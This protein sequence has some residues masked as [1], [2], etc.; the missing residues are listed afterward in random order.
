MSQHKDFAELERPLRD[1]RQKVEN[2]EAAARQ[3]NVSEPRLGTMRDHLEALERRI[4]SQ[5]DAWDKTLIAR[6]AQRPYSLDYI[7]SIFEEFVELHGDRQGADDGAIITGVGRFEGRRTAIIAQQKGRDIK[8]RKAR[9]FGM[10][11]PEGYRKAM[12]IMDLADRFGLPVVSFVDT[13]AADPGVE[14]EQRGISWAIA[15]SMR[16]MFALRV[17]T[18]AAV[19][20]EGGSGGAI[21]IACSNKVLMLEYAVYSVIPPEGCAA[22]LWRD[23]NKKNEAATALKLT[24]ADALRLG[25]VDAIV[26]EPPGAAHTYPLQVTQ[27]LREALSSALASLDGLS[28]DDLV[29][30]RRERFSGL[31]SF[32]N[33]DITATKIV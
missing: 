10:A 9:N 33:T 19:I 15:E 12:R 20:G 6:H 14:S 26:A 16:R 30:Q 18:V 28:P 4:F 2:A 11:K 31:G 25:L 5:L 22:I 21:A 23:P 24:A 1:L 29:L 7:R 13:P 17:P 27:S 3:N 32:A 8:E